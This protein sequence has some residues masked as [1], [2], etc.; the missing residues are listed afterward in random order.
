ME[1]IWETC[2]ECDGHGDIEMTD[3]DT[4]VPMGFRFCDD[5][6]GTGKQATL[7]TGCAECAGH[8]KHIYDC[9]TWDG[10]VRM[11]DECVGCGGTG[12]PKKVA[13]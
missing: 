7:E 11:T 6:S 12:N 13:A 2:C 1:R 9:I 5:C 10:L 3:S 8:G 4:T